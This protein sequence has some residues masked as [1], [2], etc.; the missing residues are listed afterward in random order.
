MPF[1]PKLPGL[2]GS[3]KVTL[4]GLTRATALARSAGETETTRGPAG[5]ALGFASTPA[6]TSASRAA[7][8]PESPVARS[9]TKTSTAP[10]GASS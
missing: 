7:L 8:C 2:I 5:V 10:V 9:F 4:T 1:T 3:L 6:W